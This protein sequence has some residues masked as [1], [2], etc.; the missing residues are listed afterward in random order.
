MLQQTILRNLAFGKWNAR[1]CVRSFSSYFLRPLE[2]FLDGLLFTLGIG[3]LLLF[4][5]DFF[6]SPG[7]ESFLPV[8]LFRKL[9]DLFLAPLRTALFTLTAAPG[10]SYRAL[11][12][13]VSIVAWLVRPSAVKTVKHWRARLEEPSVNSLFAAPRW[14]VEEDSSDAPSEAPSSGNPEASSSG[15]PSSPVV[16]STTHAIQVIG[17]YELMEELGRVAVGAVYKAL[18]LKLGR[19]VALKVMTPNGLSAEQL[20]TQKERLYREART[21]AKIMHPG[22]VTIFDI[23]EDHLGNPYIVMEFVEGQTLSRVLEQKS[24]ADPLSLSERLDLAIQIAKTLDYAHRRG[25][26]HRDIKPSNILITA[27]ANAKIADFGIAMH[28][29]A[30][31]TSESPVPGTPAYVSPELLNGFP[32]NSKSDIFSLGV[33]LYWMF[34]GE[35]PFAGETVTEIVHKVAHL[36][37]VPARRL[38][39]ALPEELDRVLRRCLAKNPA[40]RYA[41]AGEPAG[42]LVALRDGRFQTARMSA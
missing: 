29:V 27:E 34:T 23:T 10:D 6:P 5:L 16:S 9:T 31:G 13:V 42:D 1:D 22:I 19:T 2:Y 30:E 12:L 37:P 15:Y 39:W 41:N 3:L 28:L 40:D 36:N 32:A 17:R 18:D 11:P 25:V 21:A 33:V 8:A 35:M 14:T 38:N 26:V 20:R 7:L 24:N 4:C